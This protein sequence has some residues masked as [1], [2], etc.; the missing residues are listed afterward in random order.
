MVKHKSRSGAVAGGRT[1]GQFHNALAAPQQI[2]LNLATFNRRRPI[3][4]SREHDPK[5]K[6]PPLSSPTATPPS[7][8]RFAC[9]ALMLPATL[10]KAEGRTS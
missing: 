9:L 1:S 3:C 10:R 8:A 4:F 6:G 2:T 5:I 7:Q